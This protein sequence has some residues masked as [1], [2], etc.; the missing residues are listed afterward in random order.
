MSYAAAIDQLNAMTPELHTQPGHT[1]R[2]FSLAEIGTLLQTLGNPHRRFRSILIAGTNGK[3]STAATLSS[4]LRESAARSALYTSP[5]LTRPN[6]RI[7]TNGVEI[8]DDDFARLYFRVHDRGQQLV[9][10]Q[11]LAQLPSFFETLTAMAFLHFADQSVDIAVLEVGMGGRLDAT[12]IVDPLLSI[13]TDISLDH[14]EWLGPTIAAI[15]REKAGILRPNGTLIT[16]PQHPEANQVLGEIATALHVR[17]VSAVPCMPQTF[18]HAH[19]APVAS[20]ALKEDGASAPESYPIEVL[21]TTIEVASPLHGDHQHRNIALAIAAAVELATH[22]GLAITPASI[23]Q[24]IGFTQWP[25]RLEVIPFTAS[26][27]PAP[28]QVA[29]A[30]PQVVLDVAHNPAGAWALRAALRSEFGIED[31]SETP[32]VLI[33]GCLRDKP[34]AEMSQILFP[35]FQ[36]VIFAPIHSPRATPMADLLA[37]ATAV[38][39]PARAAASVEEALAWAEGTLAPEN[40]TRPSQAVARAENPCPSN[41]VP[42]REAPFA[43]R[44]AV[45]AGSVYLVGEVRPLLLARAAQS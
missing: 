38:G 11:K 24:G 14:T 12:N 1:R 19:P 43:R 20:S 30:P 32:A 15:T 39:V 7:R 36:E 33:F 40:P 3:G 23:E 29:L 31:P 5:H 17:A 26:E 45:V 10:D 44:V 25:G 28:P 8:S 2:K 6:E 42:G 13:V 16:L 22:H 18:P 41:H 27:T 9:L 34:L 37:A 35:L 21:G 4:I